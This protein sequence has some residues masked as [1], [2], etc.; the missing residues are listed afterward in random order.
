MFQK[1]QKAAQRL[2]GGGIDS[3]TG[4]R[5][6]SV[7]SEA[8]LLSL[9]PEI[10]NQIYEYVAEQTTLT[11]PPAK[12]RRL[13]LPS[14]LLLACQQTHYE[15]RPLLLSTATFVVQVL[16][17]DFSRLIRLLKSSSE[18]NV[19]S[20]SMNSRLYIS[21]L[22]SHVPSR[23]ERIA[24]RSWCQYTADRLDCRDGPN[25]ESK[26]L[27]FHYSA[28]FPNSMRPP[29]PVSR[30]QSRNEMEADLLRA[31]VRSLTALRLTLTGLPGPNS[32][33][34]HITEDLQNCVDASRAVLGPSA[35]ETGQQVQLAERLG[36]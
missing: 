8:S 2:L 7:P 6:D 34:N 26:T 5:S 24:L 19:G 28:C 10:R 9:P 21:F 36:Q 23:E 20:L 25:G 27:R 12:P 32:E 30:Y 31:H 17:Y 35:Q 14:G 29:R 4:P 3:I 11:L 1:L 22:L 15:Y 16:G 18:K 33:L 13:P